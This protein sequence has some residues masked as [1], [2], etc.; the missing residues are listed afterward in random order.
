MSTYTALATFS[1]PAAGMRVSSR[2][3]SGFTI[4]YDTE[5]AGDQRSGPSPAET[6]LSALAG[7]TSQDVAS[8]LRKKRQVPD[9]YQIAVT[10]ER[11]TEHPRVF[12]SIVVEHRI[13]GDID[14]EAVR[15]SVELSA[16][17]YCPVSAMLSA[18]VRIE[19][20]FR[21]ERTPQDPEPVSALVVTTGAE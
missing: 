12:T 10:G 14:P 17:R 4:T 8:I 20:R 19:H 7:C 9:A 3:G 21:L 13:T 16:T 11:A 5:E 2:T 18:S 6:V 1:D 15:R